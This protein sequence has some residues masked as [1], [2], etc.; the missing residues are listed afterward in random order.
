MHE[1]IPTRF[2]IQKVTEQVSGVG[3][4][5]EAIGVEVLYSYVVR[6]KGLRSHIY[7]C[8]YVC[9]YMFM[10]TYICIYKYICLYLYIYKSH[11]HVCGEERTLG[12]LLEGVR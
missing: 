5:T 7:I 4:V 3:T 2:L 10:Y 6:V 11:H 12:P 8:M 1:Y 9:I